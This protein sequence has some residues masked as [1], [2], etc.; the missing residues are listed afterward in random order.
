RNILRCV[1]GITGTAHTISSKVTLIPNSFDI[2]VKTD[3]FDSR[4]NKIVFFNPKQS[5][6]IATVAGF[7]TSI[8]VTVAG[9][10]K[11]V[12]VPAQSIYLPDHGFKTGDKLIFK[13]P[14]NV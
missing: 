14:S 1:R 10:N 3:Y 9:M 5:V 12:S 8:T 13:E 11:T 6:G 2:P 4:L 7:S